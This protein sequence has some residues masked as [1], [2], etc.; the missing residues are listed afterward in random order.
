VIVGCV[1]RGVGERF[2]LVS[3]ELESK[4][5]GRGLGGVGEWSTSD[6]GFPVLRG[7][8]ASFGGFEG[9]KWAASFEPKDGDGTFTG[10]GG[11]EDGRGGCEDDN[12]S[13]EIIRTVCLATMSVSG[14]AERWAHEQC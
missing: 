5:V 6:D 7:D 10:E 3:D 9:A 4:E 13:A 8:D 12:R 14:V 11:R 2:R 1:G